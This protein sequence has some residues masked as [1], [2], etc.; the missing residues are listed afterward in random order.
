[1]K[2]FRRGGLW[3]AVL[4]VVGGAGL[5]Y[6][7]VAQKGGNLETAKSADAF[8]GTVGVN[9]HLHYT[10]TVYANFPAVES[11]LKSLGVRHIRDGM[12]DTKWQPFYDR[13]NELGRAGIKADFITAPKLDASILLAF[14][15]RMKDSFE[16][17]E[18]PNEFDGRPDWP[19]T[20]GPY[21]EMVYKT[22][23][24][25]PATAGFPVIGPSFTKKESFDKLA[26]SAP[27]F[28]YA[29]LHNYFAGK[30]PGTQGWGSIDWNLALV[31]KAWPGKPV[32]TTET[33]YR[34]DMENVQGIPEEIAGRY[35]PRMLLEQFLHGIQRTYI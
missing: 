1:M 34:Y 25:N 18:D 32:M 8:V 12:V 30:Y 2:M 14:P 4:A 26:A 29:N 3:I 19:A 13:H 28:D 5:G 17:Y 20:L 23:K 16:A 22:V 33:G 10:D 35:M 7:A 9:V 31:D 21:M 24:S 6:R 27:F 11:A 15:S